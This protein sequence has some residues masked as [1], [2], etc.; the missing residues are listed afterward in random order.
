MHSILSDLPAVI[1]G[2]VT[3]IW[4]VGAVGLLIR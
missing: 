1:F 4:I 3:L 2:V